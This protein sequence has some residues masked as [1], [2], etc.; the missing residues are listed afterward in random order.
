MTTAL[1][2]YL[3]DVR[4]IIPDQVSGL[5]GNSS[6][7]QEGCLR[8]WNASKQRRISLPALVAPRHQLP[9]NCVA[10]LGVTAILK[11]DIAVKK[12]LKLPQFSPMICHLG[13]KKLRE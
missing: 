10:L 11:L 3:T 1:A 5:G 7:T 8:I 2:E 4:D 12:Q 13:E 9:F 6:F